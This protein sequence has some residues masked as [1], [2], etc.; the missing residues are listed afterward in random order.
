MC[1]SSTQE[2]PA[3]WP[4]RQEP[5]NQ[6]VATI[7]GLVV[8][9]TLREFRDEMVRRQLIRVTNST[10]MQERLLTEPDTCP[11]RQPLLSAYRLGED[12]CAGTLGQGQMIAQPAEA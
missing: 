4:T 2:A 12:S 7:W 1:F 8:T 11:C 9:S 5:I 10:Q 3:E 6:P